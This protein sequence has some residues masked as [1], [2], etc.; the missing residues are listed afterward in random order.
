MTDIRTMDDMGD[1]TDKRVVIRVDYN[2]PMKN[3]VI[4]DTS[5]MDRQIP[6]IE[7]LRER[8]CKKVVMMSHFGRPKGTRVDSMSLEPVAKA[9]IAKTGMKVRFIDDCMG[10]APRAAIN[11]MSSEAFEIVFLE[12]LRFYKEEEAG[13]RD[14]AVQL[15]SYG[16][17][18][19]ND[20]FATAH[21]PHASTSIIAE[22]MPAYAGRLMEEE[23]IAI[24][25][26]LEAP[27]K[28]VMGIIGGAKVSSK[29][30][31]LKNM[32]DKLDVMVLGGGIANTFL[33]ALG[34]DM[35]ES[36][37]EEE[38]VENAKTIMAKAKEKG[39]KIILPVDLIV[40]EGKLNENPTYKGAVNVNE[41]PEG[42]SAYDIGPASVKN[43]LEEIKGV[44]TI[45][46]NGTP[47]ASDFPPFD[48]GTQTIGDEISRRVAEGTLTCVAGGGETQE[49]VEKA[50]WNMSYLSTA[51]GAFLEMIE[52]KKLPG[53]EA[54]RHKHREYFGL[55][56]VENKPS[57]VAATV[58]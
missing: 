1:I 37:V 16:D 29:L 40:A 20:A 33:L 7:E 39:C 41:I 30:D 26:A 11:E 43:I 27:E 48:K 14:F 45:L 58:E 42:C 8:G 25:S 52:G 23:V 18:Y 17:I 47:G 38:M 32:V 50:K 55:N 57:V 24:E 5:R 44:K 31:V 9:L 22:M 51:G 46:W 6:T 4:T 36:L 19:I 53:V 2:L 3:G 13:D 12:N 15:A 54:L 35:K 49:A 34:Y 21:R 10:D 56:R 28:P